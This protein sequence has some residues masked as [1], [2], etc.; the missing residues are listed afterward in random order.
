MSV[1]EDSVYTLL[2]CPGS[3]PINTYALVFSNSDTSVYT[4]PA[5]QWVM[6]TMEQAP[7]TVIPGGE[8]SIAFANA[9][10]AKSN[11]ITFWAVTPPVS[12]VTITPTAPPSN[13]NFSVSPASI[14]LTPGVPF[15]SFMYSTTGA[16][17]Q[18]GTSA[19]YSYVLSGTNMNSFQAPASQNVKTVADTANYL[20]ATPTLD[21]S[22]DNSDQGKATTKVINFA[23]GAV[24]KATI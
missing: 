15:G 2:G 13:T 11:P 18:N 21:I 14:S 23:L 17:S 7:I 3:V 8:I 10:V 22:A 6:V 1:G 20:A 19:V 4:P 16:T 12:D 24:D 5:V 9:T